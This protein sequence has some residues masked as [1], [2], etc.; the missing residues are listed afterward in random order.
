MKLALGNSLES[1]S[2][3]TKSLTLAEAIV[4]EDSEGGIDKGKKNFYISET[5]SLIAINMY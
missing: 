2:K 5:W 3:P 1:T 4:V